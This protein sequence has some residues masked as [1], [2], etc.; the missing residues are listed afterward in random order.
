MSRSTPQNA[1][2]LRNPGQLLEQ[3]VRPFEVDPVAAATGV[4][5]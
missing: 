3:L 2:E 1:Y 5:R 4:Y